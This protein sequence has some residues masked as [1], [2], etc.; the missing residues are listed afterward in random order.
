M[1]SLA[2][3]LLPLPHRQEEADRLLA[4]VGA[5]PAAAAAGYYLL[6]T[7]WW[8]QRR[9]DEAAEVYRFA[10]TLDDRED[11]FAEAYFRAAR[12]TE[13]VPEALRLFQQK[14][15]RAAVPAPA[16][17]RALF[18]ALLD[19]DEPEQAFA[20]LDQAIKKL[21]GDRRRSPEQRRGGSERR[22]RSQRASATCCCSAPSATR[23]P[24]GTPQA[25][26]DL[27]AARP[28]VPPVVWHKAAARVARIKP[29]LAAAGAHYL[30]VVKLDPLSP[31]SHRTL[32]AL[33]AETDGR[34]AART[35]LAQAC[36]R[37]PHHHPLS[38]LRAEFLSGDPD[39]DAD[40]AIL[41]MLDECPR[42][43]LGAAAAGAR[44]RRPQAAR[45]GARRRRDGP[46]SSSPTT[47]GT[48]PSSPR[49]TSGPT[50]PT[51]RS[52]RS[53]TALRRN[54]DQ[55]P[56]VAELVQL[57]RGR[58]EKR[59]ALRVRRGRTPPPAAHRR[60]AGRVRR[61]GAPGLCRP[62]RP[63]RPPGTARHAGRDPRRPAGPVAGVVGRDPADGRAEPARRGARAGPRGDRPVPAAGEA[64]ARP[65][66]GVPRDGQRRGPARRAAAGGRGRAGV[67]AGGP[68]TGRGARRRRRAGRGRRGAGA[69]R[70]RSP[71]STRSP[72]ASWPSGSGTPAGRARRST[73][74]R[75]PSATSPAT[76]GRGTRCRL[77]SERLDVPG[78]AGRARP[79]TDP[80]PG[81]RPA[82]LAAARPPAAPPAAQRRGAGGA[83]PGHRARPEERRGARPEGRA[84]RR[85][86]PVRRRRWPPPSRRSSPTTCRSSCRAGVAWVEARRG[87]LRRRHPADAGA[88]RRRPDVPLGLAPARRVVQRDRPRR[89]LPRS[90]VRTRPAPAGPPGRADDARRGEAP[91]RRPRRR[92]GRPARGAEGQ[93]RLLARRR[94]AVRRLPGRRRVPRGPAGAGRA[95]GARR[96][97]GGRGQA[98]PARRPHRTT[99]TARSGR[100]PRCARGRGSRRTRSRPA[101][102]RAEDRRAGRSGRTAC[103]ARRGRAAGRSTRGCRSSGS[104][105]PTG[106]TPSR[107]S[108]CAPP[109]PCIK[110]YP[111]FMPGHDCKAEQL[112]LAGRFDEALAACKPAELATRCRSN[113]A[114]GRPGSRTA[115]ATGPRPSR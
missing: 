57:S 7:Q 6:A 89:E 110:A 20:A 71:R 108:G 22:E 8:E 86:G 66:P 43:R 9:F 24:G 21:A 11:Q 25:D 105:R 74:R 1:Q 18:H 85:D 99:P 68:R 3:V 60:G 98:D 23:R 91:D 77:W 5:E 12:A 19:R 115:A 82:R 69:G 26:A 31:K 97:A 107:A 67:V 13:Q 72:T 15:G 94:R 10:C 58:R 2:Q 36:Q 49:S 45:R 50:G 54:I 81:R 65:G 111:K 88:R 40:R 42:R 73:G 87:Q 53:A 39:A 95:A 112:A 90:R 102:A 76:T 51:T 61:P 46:A 93:P 78:R 29:D 84:A 96:R 32:T 37:F 55:E 34:A 79:R 109:R 83:R 52:P 41:D 48:S 44:P 92:Q 101:L 16:A 114:A 14:A 104:I 35:H 64:V 4:A 70:A 62:G 113:C 100:S 27:A 30:E 38:K 103:C 75:P 63:G 17:T 106:R 56:L 28:L 47:R 59:E 80:R 33:L